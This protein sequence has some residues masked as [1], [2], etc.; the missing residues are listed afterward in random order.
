MSWY[1]L[2][3]QATVSTPLLIEQLDVLR[4]MARGS[5]LGVKLGVIF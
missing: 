4:A 1:R 5:E 3:Y 2:S